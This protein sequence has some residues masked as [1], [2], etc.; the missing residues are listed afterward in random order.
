MESNRVRKAAL[1]RSLALAVAASA[2][3]RLD[4]ATI[5]GIVYDASGS[6]IQGAQ[7]V[8][9]NQGTSASFAR[10]TDGAGHFIAP[11]HPVGAY[12]LTVLTRGAR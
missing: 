6:V 12:R 2:W 3:A 1:L 9:Q 4:T 5:L 11:S 7:V 8:A 10:I